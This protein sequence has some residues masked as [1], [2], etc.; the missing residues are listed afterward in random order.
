[1][2]VALASWQ[3]QPG[4]LCL[5]SLA[6]LLAI[7]TGLNYVAF[8]HGR[9]GRSPF[10]RCL[11]RRDACGFFGLL[12]WAL[13]PALM[14]VDPEEMGTL[15]MNQIGAILTGLGI[16]VSAVEW[17]DRGVPRPNNGAARD[18]VGLGAIGLLPVYV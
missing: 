6:W 11:G 4:I 7:P 3:G 17:A 13:G 12:V 15:S 9:P 8:S 16:V 14:P 18:I 2:I 1:M 10:L 5:T